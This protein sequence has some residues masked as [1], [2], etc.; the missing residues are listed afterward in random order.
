MDMPTPSVMPAANQSSDARMNALMYHSMVVWSLALRHRYV[1]GHVR[2]KH[3]INLS[4]GGNGH[5]SSVSR[6]DLPRI[7]APVPGRGRMRN[8]IAIHEQDRVPDAEFDLCR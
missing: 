1:C 2:V 7:P 5:A 8:H 3:T 6:R 4:R